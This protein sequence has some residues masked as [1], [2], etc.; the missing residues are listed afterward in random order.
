MEIEVNYMTTKMACIILN[1]EVVT[2]IKIYLI[3]KGFS[4]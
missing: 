1:K 3:K 2:I 4:T